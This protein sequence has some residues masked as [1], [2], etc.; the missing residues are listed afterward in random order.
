MLGLGGL[1]REL[2]QEEEGRNFINQATLVI[3]NP[4]ILKGE[5]PVSIRSGTR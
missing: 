1:L 2:G 4:P 3:V 5:A